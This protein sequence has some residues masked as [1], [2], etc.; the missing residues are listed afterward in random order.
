[1]GPVTN[2][3]K[4]LFTQPSSRRRAFP[5]YILHWQHL[6]CLASPNHLQE[7]L[8]PLIHLRQ[9][10]LEHPQDQPDEYVAANLTI[11]HALAISRDQRL[12]RFHA[13]AHFAPKSPQD[14][15]LCLQVHRALTR[16]ENM[17]S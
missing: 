15:G 3:A 5:K 14:Q 12:Q 7:Q 4:D 17:R 6:I 13:A 1:M 8:I 11:A 2:A 10:V 9:K 16:Y